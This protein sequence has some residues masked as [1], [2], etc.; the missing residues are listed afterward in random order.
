MSIYSLY[1]ITNLINNKKYIGWT[2]R[3]PLKRYKEHQKTTK[4][5]HQDRSIISIAIEKYGVENFKFEVIY[6]SMDYDHSKEMEQKFVLENNTLLENMGGWGYNIDKGGNG[7]KRSRITI[8]KHRQKILGKK[9]TEEHKKKRADAIRGENNGMYGK[10]EDHPWYNR[11]HSEETKKKI[12]E[13]KKGQ[14]SRLGAVL[15]DETKKKISEAQKER[16][17]KKKELQQ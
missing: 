12:S 8:E 2:S 5:K 11:S 1:I 17:R 7:H 3:D 10:H 9:Q 6:Q 16:F 15:S 14:R 4:P 13:S